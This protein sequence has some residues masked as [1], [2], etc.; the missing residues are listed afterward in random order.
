MQYKLFI[1]HSW[2]YEKEYERLRD[3]LNEAEHFTYKSFSPSKNNS[4]TLYS[5]N[6]KNDLKNRIKYEMDKTS[7]VLI[8]ADL[9]YNNSE[10]IDMEIEV[11]S[12]LGKPI[13][14]IIPRGSQKASLKVLRIA[15]EVVHWD[16]KSI[17]EA[18]KKIYPLKWLYIEEKN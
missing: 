4:F 18:I 16:E 12:I 7:V 10:S 17:I 2:N 14:A 13:I 8:L 11:A 15:S 1:S 3:L 5:N 6:P 9:H